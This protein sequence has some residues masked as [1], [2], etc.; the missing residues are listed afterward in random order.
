MKTDQDH[1]RMAKAAIWVCTDHGTDAFNF[2][3]KDG[4]KHQREDSI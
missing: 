2:A 3:K 4:N 1:A